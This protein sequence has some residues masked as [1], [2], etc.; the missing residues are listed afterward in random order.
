MVYEYIGR[1]TTS[2][3]F[4][5]GSPEG[6]LVQSHFPIALND[7]MCQASHLGE[8]VEYHSQYVSAMILYLA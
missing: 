7:C 8:N 6:N 4:V 1:A 5:V 2:A 3:G